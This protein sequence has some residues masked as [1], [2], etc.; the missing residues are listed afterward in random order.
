MY[1]G[2]TAEA[3]AAMVVTGDDSN[4]LLVIFTSGLL[5][6]VT[7]LFTATGFLAD[8]FAAGRVDCPNVFGYFGDAPPPSEALVLLANTVR[9]D[10]G[11]PLP[12]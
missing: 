12:I 3:S 4:Q 8:F 11:L 6:G 1:L 9:L 2:L 5:D 10:R 7:D